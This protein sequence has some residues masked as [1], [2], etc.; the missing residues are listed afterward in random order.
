MTTKFK[1]TEEA[2]TKL[3]SLVGSDQPV[4]GAT[5][6]AA[7]EALGTS[8]RS[9]A[10][11]LRKMEYD[12]ESMAKKVTSAFSADETEALKAFVE[13]NP[14]RYTYAEI[15]EQFGE[16]EYSAKAIQ[17]K[18][19]SLDL[20]SLV[21]KT[22]KVAVP[23]TYTETE[24]AKVVSMAKAGKFLEEI[25]DAVSKEINS[26]RGKALSLL[27]AGVIAALPKQRDHVE[28]AADPVAEMIGEFPALTVEEIAERLDKTPRGVKVMLTRRGL[29]AK[30]YDGS[31]KAAKAAKAKEAVAA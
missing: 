11:K 9:V 24:E 7:A 23:R 3:V 25:A 6:S 30:D 18:I 2:T 21:K 22:E 12:V 15:A 13:A 14:G 19:L 16:G 5:V 29:K 8:T 26:V 31:A 27:R 1:W 10:A 28:T 4:T 20:T 17:G